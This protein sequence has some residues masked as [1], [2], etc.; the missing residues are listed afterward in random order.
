[1]NTATDLSAD[2][3]PSRTD[4]RCDS[5]AGASPGPFRRTLPAAALAGA[6]V[7]AGSMGLF[8]QE[9]D[10]QPAFEERTGSAN[11]LGIDSAP[12]V[13]RP[14]FVDLEGD[15]DLDLF[16]GRDG[17][18]DSRVVGN[19]GTPESADFSYGFAGPDARAND[20]GFGDFDGD[21]DLDAWAAVD[22]GSFESLYAYLNDG[23]SLTDGTLS[24][25]D[26]T[27]G[28]QEVAIPSSSVTF[29]GLTQGDF[30]ADGDLDVVVGRS[31]GGF[32]Y[33]AYFENTGSAT[34]AVLTR[35]TGSDNP[36][37]G[38][39]TADTGVNPTAGDLD[40]DG[41]LD[42][43]VGKA[44]GEFIYVE[45]TGS[46]TA[47]D[48][49]AQIGTTDNPLSG[50][51]VG[52]DADPTFGDLDGDG[53]LDLVAGSYAG[54][55]EYD[56]YTY[57][58]EADLF[59]FE[60]TGDITRTVQFSR[61]TQDPLSGVGLSGD[62]SPTL[63]DIDGDGDDDA[64]VG[65][66]AGSVAFYE[67]TGDAEN[68]TFVQRTGSANPFDGLGG[69]VD[70]NPA[71]G[72]LDRDGDLDLVVGKADGTL[73]YL[74]NTG[75][76][77]NPSFTERTGSDNPFD[78]VD[79]GDNSSPAIVDAFGDGALD[80]VVGAADGSLAFFTDSGDLTT[81]EFGELTGDFN[82]L[83]DVN[84][85]SNAAPRFSDLDRD[86]DPDLVVGRTD[87]TVAYFEN[88]GSA[89]SPS[90]T[91]RTGSDNPLAAVD[92]GDDSQLAF[93]DL[94]ADGDPDLAIGAADGT[95]ET[96]R[97]GTSDVLPV[98]LTA[99]T[100]RPDGTGI[101]LSWSTA[102]ETNNTGFEVQK[103]IGEEAGVYDA[104]GFV[105]GAGTTD[106]PQAYR[107]RTDDLSPGTHRFRLKQV[108][109][110]GSAEL[111]ETIA[112]DLTIE[113][114]YRLQAPAPNPASGPA[115]MGLTVERP[116]DV[117]VEVFD[118][119]GRRV[120]VPHEGAL[121][122][123]QETTIRLGGDL[124]AGTYLVRITGDAFQTTEKLTIVP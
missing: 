99:F 90:F 112:V 77:T 49:T 43:V 31:E 123:Q 65:E 36:F 9:A 25:F 101:V 33:L 5:P 72:D 97:F 32:G 116:Q 67:N 121:P 63:A 66:S 118:L 79:V 41:D 13:T 50:F 100:G 108:D 56:G 64:I 57:P 27:R 46:A 21:G 24:R 53:D 117:R 18:T 55:G 23:V 51:D 62:A 83:S 8:S 59:Y 113:S 54:Y 124:S 82:P 110:D 111:S 91:G 16:V 52:D 37:D 61:A 40:G 12:V 34:N 103:M 48:F 81:A 68:P 109:A 20:F 38:L 115:R 14:S 71:F 93:S 17:Y 28:R 39:T 74:E 75:S 45:N 29:D 76:K 3:D 95:V 105:E 94:D 86:G 85:G 120:A 84:V 22:N 88:T 73:L 70:G 104:I 7:V 102:G 107:F 1:M 122:A 10:A 69:V 106:Q 87:G 44:D 11:P 58:Y 60:N 2:S 96:Y 92:V 42:L 30:D 119:L 6:V 78:G 89:G 114:A 35:R 26:L 15:G 80:V 19:T 47:P 98:E 4:R